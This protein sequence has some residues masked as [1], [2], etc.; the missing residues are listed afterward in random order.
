MYVT[1][2]E[3]YDATELSNEEIS[4]NS[5]VGFIKSAEREVDRYTFTTYWA[6]SYS[7][8]IDTIVDSTLR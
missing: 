5:V 2:Q 3:V 7:N 6:V 1:V 8:T 4:E